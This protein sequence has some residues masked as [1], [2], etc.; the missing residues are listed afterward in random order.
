MGERV[1]ARNAVAMLA[2]ALALAQSGPAAA[3]PS[4]TAEVPQD[5]QV[6]SVGC[7]EEG[8]VRCPSKGLARGALVVI[9]G[10]ELD[11]T[12]AVVFLAGEG[13]RDD[14]QVGTR[15]VAPD[16]VTALVPAAARTGRIRVL[17]SIGKTR[18]TRSGYP[19][20]DPPVRDL[21]PHSKFFFAGRHRPSFTF[22]ADGAQ[23]VIVELVRER[24]SAVV[25]TWEVD[26][27]PGPNTVTWR[28]ASRAKGRYR[29]RLAATSRAA[30]APAV[31]NGGDF[32]FFG[33]L[34]PIRGKH[35]LGYTNTNNFGGGRGHKGQ[36]MFANCGTP[37]AVARG[38]RVRYAGYHSA[39]GNY[40]VIDGARTGLDYVYMHM[41][42][43]PLVKTGQRVFTG[44]AIGK[45]GDTGRATGCHLHF[46]TWTAPGWYRGGSAVDP[47]PRLRSW[48]AY[49]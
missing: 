24:D 41:K 33:H 20:T 7:R 18:T 6:S 12:T 42:E 13:E 47:L 37:L 27:Q 8:K 14:V 49:S 23:S 4:G 26:A 1:I 35:N 40:A 46:E 5:P 30:A 36:D 44:Q 38:G 17:S 32:R 11:A 16:E 22:N 10:T 25:K 15:S 43:P 45:V 31:E 21:A 39:A 34:F 2:L 3:S 19:I 48:D 9:R 28:G 29:F